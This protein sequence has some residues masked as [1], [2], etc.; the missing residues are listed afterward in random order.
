MGSRMKGEGAEKV[1]KA[2]E[3]WVNCA[4]RN[5]DSLFMPGEAIWTLEGL[6]VL[7]EKFL[8]SPDETPGENFYER[9][10]RQLS[11][12]Q[13][14]VYQLMGEAL[15]VHFLVIWHEAMKVDT[16]VERLNRILGWSEEWANSGKTIPAVLI[17]G[18]IRGIANPGT[19]F[20][21]YR[22]FQVG[23]IVEF[24]EQWKYQDD[25]ERARLLDDPWLFKDFL[26]KMRF[27]SELLKN[28]QD[29][30]HLQREAMLHLVFPDVF[31]GIV[32]HDHKR[33]IADAFS[34]LVTQPTND[35][36]RQLAQIRQTFEQE[37][38]SGDPLFYRDDIRRQWD[39]SLTPD[40]WDEFVR[41]AKA[42][43]DTGRLEEDEIDYKLEIGRKTSGSAGCGG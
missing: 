43:M 41:R 27:R 32:S 18:L 2:A 24:V 13:P 21:T 38:G 37:Y 10:Q 28:N 20:N 40:P 34:S 30:P 19:G 17:D 36:D 16:K 42:Y 39:P 6:G 22:P 4:L 7:H 15:Y 14:Q 12:S 25:K 33:L 35:V 5:D 9:L 1:Y 29:T 23:C 26:M 31:E 11:N 3:L 8:N